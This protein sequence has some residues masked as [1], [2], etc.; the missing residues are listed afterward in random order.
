MTFVHVEATAL[1]IEEERLDLKAA[2]VKAAPLH[3]RLE[4]CDPRHFAFVAFSLPGDH[5]Q[6]TVAPTSHRGSLQNRVALPVCRTEKISPLEFSTRVERV[7]RHTWKNTFSSRTFLSTIES[8][9]PSQKD[10]GGFL[11]RNRL[12][13]SQQRPLV[14]HGKMVFSLLYHPGQRQTT[15]PIEHRRHQCSVAAPDRRPVEDDQKRG[16]LFR[17]IGGDRAGKQSLERVEADMLVAKK[18]LEPLCAA[19]GLR[20]VRSL[21]CQL[22]DVLPLWGCDS[23]DHSGHRAHMNAKSLRVVAGPRQI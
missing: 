23:A 22:R 14:G 5:L 8:N 18:E 16:T 9:S 17:K 1:L 10:S 19:L 2:F 13:P 15:L 20:R 12:H 6:R 7:A 3:S 11:W 4:V 21:R